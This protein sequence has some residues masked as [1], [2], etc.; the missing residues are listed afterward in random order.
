MTNEQETNRPLDERLRAEAKRLNATADKIVRWSKRLSTLRN[1]KKDPMNEA[2]F[3]QKYG[4]NKTR[5]N[6]IKNLVE[7]YPPSDDLV[8]QVENAL[9]DQGV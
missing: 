6:R 1:R 4:I 5:F 7:K 2:D 3:C 8:R 9:K